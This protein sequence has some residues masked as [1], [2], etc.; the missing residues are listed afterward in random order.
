MLKGNEI[1]EI[2]EWREGS[3]KQL[4]DERIVLYKKANYDQEQSTLVTRLK[5]ELIKDH[6]TLKTE[7]MDFPVRLYDMEEF[8]Q[9]LKAN[10]F[11]HV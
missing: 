7:I 9:L 6:T 1:E 10:G 8:E 2:A 3:Q 11:Q 5:Y 4:N